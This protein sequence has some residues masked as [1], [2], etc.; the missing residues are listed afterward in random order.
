MRAKLIK[1]R[2]IVSKPKKKMVRVTVDFPVVQH[3]KLK[4][5]AALEGVTLQEY[6]RS[7]IAMTIE[8]C[9]ISDNDLKPLVRKIIKK[10][11]DI[12]KR[13]ADK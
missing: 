7:R 13:L 3:R 10:N 9:N 11:E 4:A 12:L 1:S 6:I 5:I 8:A 2:Q